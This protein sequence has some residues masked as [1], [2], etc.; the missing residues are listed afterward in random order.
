MKTKVIQLVPIEKNYSQNAIRKNE[1]NHLVHSAWSFACAAL[2]PHELIQPKEIESCKEFISH[3]FQ[4]HGNRKEALTIFC[5]RILFAK[6]YF[7]HY[8]HYKVHPVVW[9]HHN[10]D[11]GFTSTLSWYQQLLV[12]RQ[13]VP[14]FRRDLQVITNCFLQYALKPSAASVKEC[15][16]KLLALRANDLL[17]IF[18]NSIIHIHY[19]N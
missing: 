18:Y 11:E 3:Y 15:R 17:Q 10:N 16:N 2:W 7:D 1:T 12:R 6:E 13:L 19:S 14:E 9:F 4:L 8:P 5:E